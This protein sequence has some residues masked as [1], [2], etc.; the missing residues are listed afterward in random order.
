[1]KLSECKIGVV[2]TEVQ[3]EIWWCTHLTTET[4]NIGHIIGLA[5]NSA[6]EVIP[7]VLWAGELNSIPVHHKELT[8]YEG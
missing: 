5:K 2:V 3:N 1:M 7:M 6:G 4:P 8:I